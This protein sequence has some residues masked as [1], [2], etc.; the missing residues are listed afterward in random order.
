MEPSTSVIICTRN[1]VN[2]LANCLESLTK[3]T[4]HID[5]LIIVDSSDLTLKKSPQ[6]K[7]FF[8]QKKFLHTNLI[9]LHTKPGLTYQ[10][11]VGIKHAGGDIIYFFDDDVELEG[12]YLKEMSSVFKN[13]PEYAGGMGA[14]K[15]VDAP[16]SWRYRWYR[17]FFLLPRL[18]ASGKFTWSG[19]PTHPYG[20]PQFKNVEVL[21]GCCMAFRR[22]VLQQHFFDEQLYGYCYMED[23]D[24]AR[25]ISFKHQLFYN[26][27]AQLVHH[28]SPIARDQLVDRSA[29]LV[30]NYS[31]LFFKNS[32]PQNRLKII[33]YWWSLL[34]L[35]L[36]AFLMK[37]KEKIT[38]YKKGL[39]KWRKSI[40]YIAK[41]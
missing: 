17:S 4:E 16:P 7:P 20:S 30:Y 13:H 10:R 40:D 21:G 37:D 33:G 32:Y 34:G 35:F 1:R 9:Y 27:R 19:M 39:A 25:R 8:D 18:Y 12:N 36:E 41:N 23:A 15:N 28:E 29:M 26:P 14:I 2:D 3:Q 6:I 11:N 38:G 24:I 22:K 31:Y 5:E